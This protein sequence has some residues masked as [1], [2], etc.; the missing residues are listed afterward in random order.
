[1]EGF[2][3]IHFLFLPVGRRRIPSSS[4]MSCMRFSAWVCVICLLLQH[5]LQQ[6]AI[7]LIRFQSAHGLE[8]GVEQPEREVRGGGCELRGKRRSKAIS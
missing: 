5:D 1:M 6:H 4:F 2:S 7:R 8:R 3:T